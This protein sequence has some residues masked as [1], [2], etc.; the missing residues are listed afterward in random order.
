MDALVGDSE[1]G[2]GVAHADAAA[3][4]RDGCLAGLFYG[5]TVG[6][7]GSVSGLSGLFDGSAGGCGQ[8]RLG[9]ELDRR[10]VGLEPQ[11]GGFAHAGEGL[12][13][14]KGTEI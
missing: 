8:Y 12:V 3:G 11:G 4:E 5:Q 7:A 10:F 14:P 1:Y 9:G 2:G 6:G 13:D